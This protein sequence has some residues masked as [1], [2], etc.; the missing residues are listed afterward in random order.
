MFRLRSRLAIETLGDKTG[1]NFRLKFFHPDAISHCRRF[2]FVK[3]RSAKFLALF[4]CLIS[5]QWI[6]A[7]NEGL[8]GEPKPAESIIESAEFL[9]SVTTPGTLEIRVRFR[10]PIPNPD[11]SALAL[12]ELQNNPKKQHYKNFAKILFHQN[13]EHPAFTPESELSATFF[14]GAHLR[15]EKLREE[16][17]GQK[18]HFN[19]KELEGAVAHLPLVDLHVTLKDITVSMDDPRHC[20]FDRPCAVLHFVQ[21]IPNRIYRLI[22]G[23]YS[24]LISAGT[25]NAF[26]VSG[27]VFAAETDEFFAENLPR[28]SLESFKPGITVRVVA[29]G[30]AD[31]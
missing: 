12:L 26:D 31:L 30:A 22:V 11:I 20:N 19:W 24:T 6:Y 5:T 1:M 4:V 17:L 23:K 8:S 28:D 16:K 9:S 2:H 7:A 10:S 13:R 3:F 15:Q 27:D 21:K 14:P 18:T 29:Y 25:N